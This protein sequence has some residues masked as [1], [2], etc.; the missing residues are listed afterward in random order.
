MGAR[1]NMY[2]QQTFIYIY[3]YSL[4]LFFFL[5]SFFRQASRP[6]TFMSEKIMLFLLK[7]KNLTLE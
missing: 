5:I 2:V 7:R 3:I 4:Q 6:Q 1:Q